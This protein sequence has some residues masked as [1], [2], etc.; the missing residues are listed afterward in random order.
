MKLLFLILTIAVFLQTTIVPFNLVLIILIIRSLI[1]QDKYNFYLGFGLGL[2][3]SVLEFTPLGID[4]LINLLFISLVYFIS[5]TRLSTHILIVVPVVFMCVTLDAVLNSLIFKQTLQL[6]PDVLIE[7]LIA[8]PLFYFLR[9]WEE[10]FIPMKD[11]K[12]K[13][14]SK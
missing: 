14:S 12:L 3:I 9:F 1:V 5:K 2:L 7:S 11:V 8:L 10:R 4:S 6:W 13:I